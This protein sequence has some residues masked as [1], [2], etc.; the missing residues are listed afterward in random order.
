MLLAAKSVIFYVLCRL[1]YR[2][3]VCFYVKPMKFTI[4]WHVLRAVLHACRFDFFDT[5]TV[6]NCSSAVAFSM[7]VAAGAMVSLI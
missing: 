2:H 4:V 1:L 5:F 6:R 3:C 7:C